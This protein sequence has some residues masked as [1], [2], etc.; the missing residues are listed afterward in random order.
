M[1]QLIAA[2]ITGIFLAVPILSFADSD[3]PGGDD[4]KHKWTNREKFGTELPIPGY[5]E[6]MADMVSEG[7]LKKYAT[8]KYPSWYR[9]TGKGSAYKEDSLYHYKIAVGPP[10]WASTGLEA[11]HFSMGTMTFKPGTVYPVHN[12]PAWEVYYIL[13]GQGIIRKYDKEYKIRPGDYFMNRPYDVH[14]IINTS[15]DK[16]L[17]VM[18]TWWTEGGEGLV[19]Y[20]GGVPVMPDKCWKDR[21]SACTSMEPP[22]NLKGTDRHEFMRNLEPEK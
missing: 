18:W 22:R 10:S 5:R 4:S 14:S 3:R 19:F 13:E 6:G 17:R 15:D 11:N 8:S 12:H 21:E 9:G 20:K 7:E 1:K 16:P 2:L